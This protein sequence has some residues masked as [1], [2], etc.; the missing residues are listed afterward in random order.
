MPPDQNTKC[1]E[2][3]GY[4]LI[5]EVVNT[6]LDPELQNAILA[7]RADS[8]ADPN[9]V[10]GGA[11]RVDVL[12]RLKDVND[13]LPEQLR[14]VQRVGDVVAGSVDVR[15]IVQVRSHKNIHS[16]KGAKRVHEALDTS[17]PEIGAAR[18]Q[19]RSVFRNRD[20]DGAGVIVGVVDH[21]CDFAHPNFRNELGTRILYLW[22]QRSQSANHPPP[23]GYADG[24]EFTAADIDEAL[25]LAPPECY[26]ALDYQVT[27]RPHG[28][29]VLDIAAGSGG[30]TN[31]P[32]VA[33]GA[34][35]I[36]VDLASDDLPAPQSFGN[37]RHLFNAVKYIFEKADELAER[38]G[39]PRSVVVNVS[40][41]TDAGPHDGSSPFERGLDHLLQKPGRAVVLAAGNSADR[42][43][44]NSGGRTLGRHAARLLQ[45]EQPASLT[46]QIREGDTT[47]NIADIWY[48]GGQ[49]LV[50]SLITPAGVDIGDFPLG[51]TTTVCRDGQEAARVFHRRCDPNNDDNEVFLL[52]RTR[53]EPGDWTIRFTS[54][55]SLP[56]TA[57]AW[58]VSPGG[59]GRR[60]GFPNPLP[61]DDACTISSIACGQFP[62]AVGAYF[63]AAPHEILRDSSEGPTRD[64]KW[65]PEVSAPGGRAPSGPAGGGILA[66]HIESTLSLSTSSG[67]TS[68]AAPHVA[69]LIALLM[70]NAGGGL[71]ITEIRDR[72]ISTARRQ[73]PLDRPW[74]P[75]FGAGRIEA[76]AALLSRSQIAPALKSGAAPKLVPQSAV[77]AATTPAQGTEA[78]PVADSVSITFEASLKLGEP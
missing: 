25:K 34:D 4:S 38:E 16:L 45:P 41:S 8:P 48:D 10:A 19:L 39:S 54:L 58:A 49:E 20:V 76:R 1:Q 28:T 64:G 51:T 50:I 66:A 36:F 56:F 29:R 30:G 24:R 17:V 55:G 18:E 26:L 15:D 65:K 3:S 42:S 67:G 7:G 46:W 47:D 57:H 63:S 23:K 69:G 9:A 71:S 78:G 43:G 37:S 62:I 75:R 77:A 74:H 52:F 68:A 13:E 70:Q 59:A 44:D 60:S 35:I 21:G 73:P 27:G 31:P 61:G 22:D 14:D 32:G 72:V 33:P 2:G 12:A 6:N 11:A 40:L 5:R 53:M